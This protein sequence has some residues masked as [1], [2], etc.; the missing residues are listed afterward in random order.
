MRRKADSIGLGAAIFRG[1]VFV[2]IA[3]AASIGVM[4]AAEFL[5]SLLLQ[6]DRATN[7]GITPLSYYGN[8]PAS[9]INSAWAAFCG[10]AV[11][12]YLGRLAAPTKRAAIYI[13]LIL[14]GFGL[15][16][17]A[18]PAGGGVVP[19]LLELIYLGSACWFSYAL[20]HEI[21]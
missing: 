13:P 11:L 4:V 3:V 7:Q 6:F 10:G 2:P 14:A 16:V 19:L 15:C 5:G 18:H 21:D 20:H 17:V 8:G 9:L 12:A 1:V